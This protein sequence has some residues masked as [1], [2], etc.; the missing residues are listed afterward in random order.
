M[1]FMS[2][3]GLFSLD[4]LRLERLQVIEMG[5]QLSTKPPVVG[6]LPATP[7]GWCGDAFWSIRAGNQLL[8]GWAPFPPLLQ[9]PVLLKK[10]FCP[11]KYLLVLRGDCCVPV[12]RVGH[13]SADLPVSP[14]PFISCKPRI[15]PSAI[16]TRG[17]HSPGL[18]P[19]RFC[20]LAG[21]C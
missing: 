1:K 10:F 5:F 19:E 12:S 11:H 8:K 7:L 21:R 18:F 4:G 20:Q 6:L 16:Q 14:V 15:I 13:S 9:G 2:R 3:T 17:L